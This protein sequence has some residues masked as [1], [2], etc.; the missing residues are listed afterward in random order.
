MRNPSRLA[1]A[2]LFAADL[3]TAQEHPLPPGFVD[4]AQAIPGIAL[5]LRYAGSHNFI[6][7]PIDGY[8][9]PR[10]L[11]TH[12]AASALAKAQEE[13]APFGFGLKVFDGYR[14]QR[15]VDHFVRWSKDATDQKM[16]SEFYPQVDKAKLFELGYIAEQ[17]GH[18]RGSTVDL[19]LVDRSTGTELDMGSPYDLF[20]PVSWPDSG[21]VSPV[22]RAHRLLLR[23]VMLRAGFRPYAQEWW[24][25]TLEG[26]PFPET[27][28]DFPVE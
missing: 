15:A 5:D 20:D 22:Q 1:L 24:H 8:G 17:S 12:L 4:L 25:F 19:T 27:Y 9:K 21:N 14:P 6:G 16:K 7:V 11:L 2:L 10:A 28:F 13:L 18:S 26:E 23:Q 3:S